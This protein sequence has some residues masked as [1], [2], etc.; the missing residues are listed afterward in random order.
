MTS[1]GFQSFTTPRDTFVSQST[2]PAINTQD[3]LSQIAQ[4]LAVIDPA[5]QKYIVKKIEDI[6][7]EEVAE[8]QTEGEE[9]ARSYTKKQRLLFPEGVEIDETAPDFAESVNKL[10]GIINE[11]DRKIYQGKSIWYKN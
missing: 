11:N 1:S 6:R 2:Q 10:S 9:A 7:D 3:G 8:A 5:L 4:T